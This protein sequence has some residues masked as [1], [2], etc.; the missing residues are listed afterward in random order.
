MTYSKKAP[1]AYLLQVQNKLFMAKRQLDLLYKRNSTELNVSQLTH[2]LTCIIHQSQRIPR[3][4]SCTI[5]MN[6]L[7]LHQI[8]DIFTR[9]SSQPPCVN[10]PQKFSW[11]RKLK[12]LIAKNHNEHFHQNPNNNSSGIKVDPLKT[13]ISVQKTQT[14][15]NAPIKLH[16][17][18]I[19]WI[20]PITYRK[21]W[22]LV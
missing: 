22:T 10:L 18:A 8:K 3:K 2:W 11:Q 6:Q 1:V 4:A 12:S 15:H 21:S 19:R 14:L 7:D 17:R 9:L 5:G 16:S 13:L 20:T